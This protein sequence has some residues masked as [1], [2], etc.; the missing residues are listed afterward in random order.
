MERTSPS[1][2]RGPVRWNQPL[3]DLRLR[4]I[5]A[6]PQRDLLAGGLALRPRTSGCS[7]RLA[8]PAE[9]RA[10]QPHPGITTASLRASATLAFFMPCRPATRSAQALSV[11]K[12]TARVNITLA[13]SNSAVRTMASPTLLIRPVQSTSPDWY[14][15]GVS[16]KCAPTALNLRNAQAGRWPIGT[17][18]RPPR[19]RPGRSS[20]GHTRRPRGPS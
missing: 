11:E 16:P 10:V 19:P 18:W 5:H 3:P 14:F 2:P 4:P 6:S 13:A 17:S 9:C 12:R 1:K 8:A 20:G 7:G 15:F